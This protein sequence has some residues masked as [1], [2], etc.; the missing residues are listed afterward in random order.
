MGA[1]FITLGAVTLL[2]AWVV[3]GVVLALFIGKAIRIADHR[4]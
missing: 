4:R 2:T 1:F 3:I